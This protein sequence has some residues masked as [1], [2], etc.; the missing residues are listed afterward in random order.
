MIYEYFEVRDTDESVLDLNLN[1]ILHRTV[2]QFGMGRNHN[3]DEE[4]TRPGNSG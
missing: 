3:R 1:E 2:V 4:A